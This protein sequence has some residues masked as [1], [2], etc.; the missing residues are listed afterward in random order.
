MGGFTHIYVAMDKFTK[1]IK[2]KPVTA[3]TAAKVAEFI[4]EISYKFGVPNRI[5]TGGE[6]WDNC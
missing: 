2:V 4:Q 6:F 3:T 1:W 5:I